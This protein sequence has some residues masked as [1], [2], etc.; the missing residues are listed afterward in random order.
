MGGNA[1]DYGAPVLQSLD[2]KF[3]TEDVANLAM[4]SYRQAIMDNSFFDDDKLVSQ[5]F[6][7]VPDVRELFSNIFD[8]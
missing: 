6:L 5:Y 4:M 2:S 7:Y 8:L 3:L 1:V